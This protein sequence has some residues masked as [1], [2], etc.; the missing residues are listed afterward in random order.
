MKLTPEE[1][2]HLYELRDDMEDADDR[3]VLRRLIRHTEKLQRLV[4]KMRELLLE[5]EQ[6]DGL[7]E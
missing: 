4:G 1:W 6:Q 7:H 2:K 3:I 5:K